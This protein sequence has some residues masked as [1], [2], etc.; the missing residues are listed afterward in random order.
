MPYFH[1]L[2]NYLLQSKFLRVG[3]VLDIY[4]SRKSKR[5]VPMRESAPS[6]TSPIHVGKCFVQKIGSV[7]YCST[8]LPET[9]KWG[10]S[11][12]LVVKFCS[13]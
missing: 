8:R 4:Y 13:S 9:D 3:D 10:V 6:L 11:I 2:G 7:G 5:I 1:P 12:H